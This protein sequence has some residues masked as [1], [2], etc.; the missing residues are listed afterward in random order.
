MHAVVCMHVISRTPGSVSEVFGSC[1]I[2]DRIMSS[3][4]SFGTYGSKLS[5]M[6]T[7]GEL[8][9]SSYILHISTDSNNVAHP[10]HTPIPLSSVT[11]SRPGISPPNRHRSSSCSLVGMNRGP[12]PLIRLCST[13]GI[14]F[15]VLVSIPSCALNQLITTGSPVTGFGAYCS[16]PWSGYNGMSK[17]VSA[18]AIM[19]RS[20]GGI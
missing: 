11:G 2:L 17:S 14:R 9:L 7:H 1:L 13:P 8:L 4:T 12:R 19:F 10:L 3:T 15:P 6:Y 18:W 16:V 20:I 5:V